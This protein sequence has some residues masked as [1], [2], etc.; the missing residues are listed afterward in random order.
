MRYA[1]SESRTGTLPLRF[2]RLIAYISDALNV[3]KSAQAEC[4]CYKK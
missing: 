4:L 2:L 3:Q 1:L